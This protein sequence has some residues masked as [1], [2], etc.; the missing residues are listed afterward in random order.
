MPFTKPVRDLKARLLP[1]TSKNMSEAEIKE[2]HLFIDLLDRC[3]NLN[4]EK[5]C[6]PLEALKHPFVYRAKA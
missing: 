2:I 1:T 4:P 3:L 6:T 5:R